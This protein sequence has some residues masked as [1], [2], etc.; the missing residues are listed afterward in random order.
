MKQFLIIISLVLLCGCAALKQGVEDYNTGKSTALVNGEVS[1]S[2]QAAAIAGPIKDLPVPYAGPIG[3]AIGFIALQL[4]TWKRGERIR[5]TG[6]PTVTVNSPSAT[7]NMFIGIEQFVA[8]TFAGAFT[9]VQNSGGLTGTVLQRAWKVALATIASGTTV[10]MANPQ[11]G[12]FLTGHPV[13]D[14][15]FIALSSGIAGMEKALSAV[16]TVNT[17]SSNTPTSGT[18]ATT[19]VITA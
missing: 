14:I 1:P 2:D 16:P 10:G 6:S 15:I 7:T 5:K 8:N 11:V 12:S 3:T 9:T 18:N 17:P 4:F 19:T 13:L